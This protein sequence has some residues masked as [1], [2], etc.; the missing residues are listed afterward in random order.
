MEVDSHLREL[1]LLCNTMEAQKE[2]S[3]AYKMSKKKMRENDDKSLTEL[4]Y[5][6]GEGLPD[7][8]FF[9]KERYI[10]LFFYGFLLEY[11]EIQLR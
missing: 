9:E 8:I 11:K 2:L 5:E 4:L 10:F 6:N 7:H 3:A 1:P